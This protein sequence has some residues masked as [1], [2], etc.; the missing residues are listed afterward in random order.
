[1]SLAQIST[2][3]ISNGWTEHD[4]IKGELER[5]NRNWIP[6]IGFAYLNF[7][8]KYYF[9]LPNSLDFKIFK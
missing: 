9:L 2:G 1:M 8:W 4:W 3:K 5:I 7:E 6:L